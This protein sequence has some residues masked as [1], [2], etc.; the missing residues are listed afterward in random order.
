MIPSFPAGIQ[1]QKKWITTVYIQNE[2]CHQ[3][4]YDYTYEISRLIRICVL[5]VLTMNLSICFA[6]YH[7]LGFGSNRQNVKSTIIF[8]LQ[9]SIRQ[10]RYFGSFWHQTKV[11]FFLSHSCKKTNSGRVKNCPDRDWIRIT[12]KRIQIRNVLNCWSVSPQS[13]PTSGSQECL[14][15]SG[16]STIEKLGQTQQLLPPPYP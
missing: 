16:I 4:L 1:Q 7:C 11:F 9:K 6:E 14:I 8:Q 2:H 15:V 13:L 12:I 10:L 3:L 5:S